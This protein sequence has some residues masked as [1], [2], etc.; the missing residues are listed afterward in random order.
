MS[1]IRID[2]ASLIAATTRALGASGLVEEMAAAVA[3]VL[4]KAEV[5]GHRTHGLSLL[6]QYLAQLDAGG[7]AKSGE[8]TVVK[9]FGTSFLWQANRLPGAWVLKN[10][11]AQMSKRAQGQPVIIASIAQCFHIG[12]LQT[13]LQ[14]ATDQG[15]ICMISATDPAVSSVAPFGGTEP[16]LTSNPVAYGLPTGGDPILI[17]LCT[18]VVSNSALLAYQ[19]ENR[20]LPS[21]W[22]LD[23]QGHPTDDPQALKTE[24]PG[25]IMPIGG[26][27]F[28][29]KGFALGLTVEALALGLSGYGRNAGYESFGEGVFVQVINPEFFAGRTSFE[30]EMSRLASRCRQSRVPPGGDPVRMPGER[31]LERARAANESGIILSEPIAAL[32]RP[33]LEIMPS[34]AR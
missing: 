4:V 3:E 11:I 5:M 22:L 34:E 2:T 9:D 16:V 10:A 12:S 18:S 30:R 20:R 14:A 23:N 29:Y 32:L 24:P 31:A 1:E 27:E 8:V 17:D 26:K 33:W 28:G 19:K 7:M 25:T 15:L 13:Y 21:E 6:P